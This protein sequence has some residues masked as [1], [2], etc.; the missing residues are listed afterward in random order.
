MKEGLGIHGWVDGFEESV[1]GKDGGAIWMY[2]RK[3]VG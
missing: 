1:V 3:G 2:E